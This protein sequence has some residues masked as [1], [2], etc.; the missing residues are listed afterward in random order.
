M[1]ESPEIQGFK[2]YAI[3]QSM[4]DG[5]LD[6]EKGMAA[7]EKP[8]TWSDWKTKHPRWYRLLVVELAS[9]AGLLVGLIW[10]LNRVQFEKHRFRDADDQPRAVQPAL[11]VAAKLATMDWSVGGVLP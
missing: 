1:A 7:N 3:P 9:I 11:P 2:A 4:P 8:S 5:H 6:H 10:L